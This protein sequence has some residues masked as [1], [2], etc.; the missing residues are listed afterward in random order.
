M[1]YYDDIYECA[2]DNHYLFTTED[3]AIAEI[4]VIEL[5]KLASRGRLERLGNGVYRLARYVPAESDPYAIAVARVGKDAFLYGESVIALLGLA[6]TN[7]DR[8]YVATPRRVRKSLP[9]SI[10]LVRQP[11]P[12]RLAAYDS[13][14]S[15]RVAD[16]IASCS[17]TVME[18]RLRDAARR[19]YEAGYI[20]ASEARALD[21]AMGW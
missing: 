9:P 19:G 3:A 16:A 21:E 5:V 15:Q 7:P 10:V 1:T 8:I 12:Q 20:T 17:E 6:P 13:I 2:V 4:P 14:V 11:T 18:G